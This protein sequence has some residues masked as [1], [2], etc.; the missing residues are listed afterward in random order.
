MEWLTNS[1]ASQF[2]Y[3]L[4][5]V[6][7]TPSGGIVNKFPSPYTSSAPYGISEISC[8]QNDGMRYVYGLPTYNVYQMDATVSVW[9]DPS[10]GGPGAT[11]DPTKAFVPSQ[12]SLD[13]DPRRI[14]TTAPTNTS[15]EYLSQTE[16]TQPYAN[17][18][19][20]TQVLSDD[21]IDKT[22]NGPSL[23]D[24][25]YWVKFDYMQ[26]SGSAV[27]GASVSNGEAMGYYHWRVPYSNSNYIDGYKQDPD[28]D[29]GS[30]TYGAKELYY[31]DSIETK[32]HIVVFYT[33]PRSDAV[34]VKDKLSGG[35]ISGGRSSSTQDLTYRL[36]SIKLFSRASF[37]SAHPLAIKTAHFVYD[38]SLCPGVPNNNSSGGKLTLKSIYFT[39]QDSKRG[40]ASPYQFTYSE[41][42][43]ACTGYTPNI[44]PS[45]DDTYI[46]RWGTYKDNSGYYTSGRSN[47]PVYPYS[48]FPYTDQYQCQSNLD[49]WA[50]AWQ[51]SSISLPTGGTINI[52]YEMK[53]YAYV[54]NTPAQDMYD[55]A[56]V[57]TAP[58]SSGTS[59][60]QAGAEVDR[61]Q[62]TN[63]L[64]TASLLQ[65]DRSLVYFKLKPNDP[66]LPAAVSNGGQQ[67]IYQN[68]LNNGS[69]NYVYF[70]AFTQ[71]TSA[72]L[73]TSQGNDYV[74]GYANVDYSKSMG[75]VSATN[76]TTGVVTY[77]GYLHLQ[78][79]P[80]SKA[81]ISGYYVNPISRA[82]IEHLR[83]DRPE[84]LYTKY[85]YTTNGIAQILN[86]AAT[87]ISL[88]PQIWASISGFNYWAYGQNYGQTIYLNGLSVIRLC[89]NTGKKYGGGARVKQLTLSDNWVNTTANNYNYGQTYT[90]TTDGTAN[91]P[92]SGVAYEPEQGCDEDAL[93]NPVPYVLSEP[94]ASNQHL[95]VE[96]PVLRDYYPGASVGYSK[97]TVTSIGKTEAEQESGGINKLT[98]TAAPVST[99]EFY[100]AKDFP[101]ITDETD[102]ND[103]PAI[104]RPFAIPGLYTSF[105]KRKARSQGYSVIINDMAGKPKKILVYSQGTASNPNGNFISEQDFTYQTM[106]PY[107]ANNINELSSEVQVL[108]SNGTYQTAKMGESSE[109]FIDMN[110]NESHSN[111]FGFSGEFDLLV[112]WPAVFYLMFFPYVSQTGASMRTSVV[113]KVIYRT[114]ILKS[115][116]TKTDQSKI[117][118]TNLA[119]DPETGEP[120]LTSVNNEFDDN[121]Y[122]YSIPAYWYY[123]NM[124]GEY[125]NQGFSLTARPPLHPAVGTFSTGGVLSI[126]PT[127]FPSTPSTS[128][129][130]HVENYFTAGDEI[131][132][133]GSGLPPQTCSSAVTSRQNIYTVVGVYPG[134]YNIACIDQ[135]GNYPT[136]GAI[137]SLKII[138]SGYRNLQSMKAGSVVAKNISTGIFPADPNVPTSISTFPS[139]FTIDNT[140][141]IDAKA[142]QYNDQWRVLCCNQDGGI[143]I[144]YP[145]GGNGGSGQNN[146]SPEPPAPCYC[147]NIGQQVNP[148]LIGILGTWRPYISYAYVTNRTQNNNIRTDG[149]FT[150]FN[151]FDWANPS[152]S[153]P[154]WVAAN[155]ITNYSPYGFELEN[156]NAI[157]IYSAATYG[158]T[159]S[160]VTAVASNSQY[161]EIG[162]DGFEDYPSMCD[163]Q[164][165]R[166]I[167]AYPNYITNAQAHTG[168]YSLHLASGQSLSAYYLIEGGDCTQA[169]PTIL[170]LGD[171]NSLS[172]APCLAP[173]GCFGGEIHMPSS[174]SQQPPGT[175]FTGTFYSMSGCDCVGEFYPTP[176]S[177]YVIGAWVRE[178]PTG[179]PTIPNANT[180]IN[181]Q[182]A[183]N[184]F[185]TY[186]SPEIDIVCTGSYG[187]YTVKSLGSGNIIDGWQRIYNTFT[188]PVGTTL[189][190]LVLINNTTVNGQSVS[191][192][193]Y[194]DD[195]RVHPFNGNMNTYVY[196]NKLLRV[197]AEL[198]PNN[199]AT[200]YNYDDEGHLTKIKKETIEGIETVK[201]GRINNIE[202]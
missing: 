18:W 102:I 58:I 140:S 57:G 45:Y 88:L 117:V 137:T 155:T 95:F 25:G 12:N 6:F 97:V 100:T 129:T 125:L 143:D 132:I 106:K 105:F 134:T 66:N 48:D 1:D 33:S 99:Y 75:V 159:N 83:A 112:P 69:L 145:Q 146:D 174:A 7:G 118:Q 191:A 173:Q 47:P 14:S 65:P 109:A 131:Y 94:L 86:W 61:K 157:G 79:V 85:P 42:V 127:F 154:N 77:Y 68:C 2:G 178:I 26:T 163:D 124:D 158:Y 187:T 160:L 32:T 148:Y 74:S 84:L 20:L 78:N 39:Y 96:T 31:I 24:Y 103:D 21:Y 46:D 198:D 81:N 200:L 170:N 37:K 139:T 93:H 193:D 38:Y 73:L 169:Q 190:Q 197:M 147:T 92:S 172:P 135:C 52:A 128:Y 120:L 44:N 43:T 123:G 179:S 36:D 49:G 63:G 199:Y 17:S 196:D 34:G 121:V 10:S 168:N 116:T 13:I 176:G 186:G 162:F 111:E 82:A 80:L 189:V 167:N 101:I 41:P 76:S 165:F 192:D 22:G 151:Y 59:G 29:K 144:L 98:H 180:S 70:K 8:V 110:E 23:D 156:K 30:L 150:T 202:N 141:I 91:G 87:E 15:Q 183:P 182:T 67:Y 181:N 56:Q 152:A 114:G 104:I 71:L 188:P 64:N 133:T 107:D 166:F 126:D 130:T 53:D 185:I 164:H 11:G 16:L 9:G 35:I 136:T 177:E 51:L 60:P 175:A 4:N 138:K 50:S 195:L 142:V 3:S 122:N 119:Y 72:G 161:H 108:T 149:M 171:D 194:F 54:E 40:Q 201:E 184:T 89:D 113:N 153:D 115:T 90:Y 62:Q 55:I 5:Q 27:S 19:L 28:D